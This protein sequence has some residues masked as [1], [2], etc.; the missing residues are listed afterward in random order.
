MTLFKV[1]RYDL[2]NSIVSLKRLHFLILPVNSAS[3]RDRSI[4]STCSMC[5]SLELEY[6]MTWL[7]WIRHIFQFNLDRIMSNSRW[8]VAGAFV[9][10]NGIQ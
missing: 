3:L 1:R 7:R 10:L 8:K 6:I 5:S 4:S 9:R 2:E